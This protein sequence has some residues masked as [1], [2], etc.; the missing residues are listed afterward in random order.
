MLCFCFFYFLPTRREILSGL[1]SAFRNK[2]CP[3]DSG[4]HDLM[5]VLKKILIKLLVCWSYFSMIWKADGPMPLFDKVL[6]QQT[7]ADISKENGRS[8]QQ[9]Q[10]FRHPV[11]L[12][13]LCFYSSWKFITFRN[14]Y[15]STCSVTFYILIKA[16]FTICIYDVI[17]SCSIC[18]TIFI[19]SFML[20]LTTFEPL[21]HFCDSGI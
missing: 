12:F 6:Y 8:A 10:I 21:I 11:S 18:L 15:L 20:Q 4:K 9:N 16:L 7:R 13:A 5:V 19:T 2:M 17:Q 14:Y 1:F 3:L